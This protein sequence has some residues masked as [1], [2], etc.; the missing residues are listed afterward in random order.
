MASDAGWVLGVDEHTG[1]IMDLDSRIATVVG[2]G[3][4][5]VRRQGQSAT[6]ESGESVPLGEMRNLASGTS[7]PTGPSSPPPEVSSGAPRTALHG[8]IRRLED[9]FDKAIES[10][11][12]ESAV[13]CILELLD[14]LAAWSGDTTQS[15][16]SERGQAALR[17]MIARVGVFASLGARDPREII[18]PFVDGLIHER[19]AARTDRRYA[20]ADRIRDL[21]M[22]CGVEV[23]DTTGGTEW[24]VSN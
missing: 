11:D 10:A 16:A 7:S 18:G 20:D 19:D 17:R 5:T 24:H 9:Q 12:V 4:V 8:E 23:R 22:S 1:L 13:G 3:R 15:D 21:L 2:N 6:L 14:T